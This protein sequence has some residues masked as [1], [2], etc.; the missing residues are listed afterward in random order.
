MNR[1]DI[2]YVTYL[3]PRL[4]THGLGTYYIF[5]GSKRPSKEEREQKF[6]EYRE[7]LLNSDLTLMSDLCEWLESA[8]RRQTINRGPGSYGLKHVAERLLGRYVSNGQ[9]ICAAIHCGL[10]YMPTDYDSPNA[11]FN[12]SQVWV[13]QQ[14]K[15]SKERV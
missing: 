13:N 12:L 4:S 8:K 11:Y 3:E 10:R 2:E 15:L 1:K 5:G 9:L 7:E 14:H 6:A